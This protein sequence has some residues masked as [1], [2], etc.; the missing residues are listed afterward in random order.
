VGNSDNEP[1]HD[2]LGVTGAA[3][4]WN[5]LMTYALARYNIPPDNFTMPSDIHQAQVSS[6]TGLAPRVGEPT[7]SDWFID[8]SVPT[9]QG[10]AAPP[11]MPILTPVPSTQ[12]DQNPQNLPIGNG[13]TEATPTSGTTNNP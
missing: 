2:I 1:M 12:N 10:V 11:P 6:I 9:I 8:G 5:E 7:V 3:P 13:G 4:V